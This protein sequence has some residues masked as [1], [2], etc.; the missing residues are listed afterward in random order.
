MGINVPGRRNLKEMVQFTLH[1]CALYQKRLMGN[2]DQNQ[3][4]FFIMSTE[5][6]KKEIPIEALI[7]LI[8]KMALIFT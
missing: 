5:F 3:S 6:D 8:T 4:K 7:A 2:I 1:N